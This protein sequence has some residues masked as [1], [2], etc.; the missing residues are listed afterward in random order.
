MKDKSLLL[1]V[2]EHMDSNKKDGRNEHALI[3]CSAA[4]RKR[5][6][7][8]DSTIDVAGK[9]GSALL[10]IH[11]A[12]SADLKAL[13]ASGKISAA[14]MSKVAFVTSDVMERLVADKKGQLVTAMW[15]KP[16]L[17]PIT[18]GADPEFLLFNGNGVVRANGVIPK[19]GLVGSDGAMIEV[20]PDPSEDPEVVVSN[21][22]SIF[23]NTSLVSPIVP[24]E[25]KAGIYFKDDQR[26][27]PIGGHIHIGNPIG[28]GR[29]SSGARNTLFAVVNKVLDELLALP[30]VK[31]D[32]QELGRAR[33]SDCQMAAFGTNGYGFYGEWRTCQGRLEH[34]TL[35]GIWL[36]H[37][38]L[39]SLVLGTAKAIAEAAYAYVV[40]E[41]YKVASFKHDDIS[42]DD[43]RHLYGTGF[44][45]WEDIP[46]AKELDCVKGS[47]ELSNL[48][49]NSRSSS[50]S[51]K[52][53]R[54]WYTKMQRLET[55][56]AYAKYIDGLYEVLCATTPTLKKIDTDIK[57]N[58]VEGS[59]F[60]I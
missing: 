23:N 44:N 48:L 35:S 40:A 49:N 24:Y 33:R 22:K 4:V 15:Q 16:K 46:M 43:H 51:K 9:S 53:L 37:P 57:R 34:R 32:G 54:D 21:I 42:H 41:N 56:S 25:W 14:D 31:L 27:Y 29:I 28:I 55:Y 7:E 26:D 3:R 12:F 59:D 11:Q 50:I 2:S 39:A 20:R 30:M 18:L 19:A 1:I 47:G 52:F 13:K 58:W 45:S 8:V 36:A 6:G 10:N 5:L 17:K 38:K 60:I